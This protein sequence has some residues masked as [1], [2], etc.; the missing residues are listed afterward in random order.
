MGRSVVRVQVH[1]LQI[2]FDTPIVIEL[3]QPLTATQANVLHILGEFP[4]R[5]VTRSDLR[6]RLCLS[7]SSVMIAVSRLRRCLP[8]ADWTIENYDK[9]YRLIDLRDK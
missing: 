7:Y 3:K 9:G 1:Q 2:G 5:V 4:N 8:A 6:A